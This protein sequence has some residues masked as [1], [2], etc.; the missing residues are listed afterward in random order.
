M[1]TLI[2]Q[3]EQR[4]PGDDT[5]GFELAEMSAHDDEHIYN[6]GAPLLQANRTSPRTRSPSTTR[7]ESTGAINTS[8]SG[9]WFIWA[10]TFSAGISG[11][12]FGYEYDLSCFPSLAFS[13]TITPLKLNLELELR[14]LAREKSKQTDIY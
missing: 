1:H 6:P 14:I 4:D 12:L 5:G 2:S 9:T 11:L 8:G 7:E 3:K 13:A 10:L